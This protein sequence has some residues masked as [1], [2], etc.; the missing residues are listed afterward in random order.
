M[1]PTGTEKSSYTL[2]PQDVLLENL[3]R[4][5]NLIGSEN[6]DTHIEIEI[7]LLL[8]GALIT[9][10]L[11]P[12][13]VWWKRLAELIPQQDE[14]LGAAALVP[15]VSAVAAMY[16]RTNDYVPIEKLHLF[17]AR[18]RLPGSDRMEPATLWRVDLD[19]VQGFSFGHVS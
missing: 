19:D 12:G 18:L 7:T 13:V 5:L 2:G 4:T 14:S 6:P 15:A 11:V 1:S 17:R 9:G 3:Q 8:N 10:H 16:E